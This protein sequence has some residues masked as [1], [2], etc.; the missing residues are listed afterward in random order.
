MMRESNQLFEA[1]KIFEP[2]SHQLSAGGALISRDTTIKGFSSM[3]LHLVQAWDQRS[4]VLCG[5]RCG[6]V[7]CLV[8][9]IVGRCALSRRMADVIEVA[10]AAQVRCGQL[11][12]AIG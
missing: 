11:S 2:E 12:L 4:R 3:G 7:P 1:S 8:L 9:P 6:T 5:V 10:V